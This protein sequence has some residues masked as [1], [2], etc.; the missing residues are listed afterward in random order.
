MEEHDVKLH[1]DI[2]FIKATVASMADGLKSHMLKEEELH[3]LHAA[4]LRVLEDKE[5]RRDARSGLLGT[6][7]GACISAIAYIFSYMNHR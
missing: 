5:I 6:I 3:G 1:E 2:G 7:G 4:R